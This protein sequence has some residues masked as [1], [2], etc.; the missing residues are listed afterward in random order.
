MMLYMV[1]HV[2][3]L[4]LLHQRLGLLLHSWWLFALANVALVALLVW[5]AQLWPVV[6]QRARA[7]WTGL[8]RP[9]HGLRP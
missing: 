4:T 3:A 6:K 5:L 9:A 1:H 8:R 7:W 2:I